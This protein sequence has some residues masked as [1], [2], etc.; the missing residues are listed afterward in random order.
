MQTLALPLKTETKVFD[1]IQILCCSFLI[2][3]S[4]QIAIP[5]PFTPIP[6]TLQTFAVLLIGIKLG[7][8]KGALAVIAYLFE[9]GLGLP[10]L[11]TALANP[12]VLWGIKAGYYLGFVMQAFLVGFIASQN[13]KNSTLF[14]GGI[15]ACILELSLGTAW[16]AGFS[17]WHNAF[18]MGFLPFIPGEILK[19]YTAV[20]FSRK[21]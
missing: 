18:M 20:R 8:I 7:P 21:S 2:A 10:F 5:L 15:I 16:L 3:L 1:L 17:G 11:P 14:L 6:L 4:A 12:A 13:V 9:V 19:V